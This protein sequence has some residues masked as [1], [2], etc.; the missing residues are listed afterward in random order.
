MKFYI[1]KYSS[2]NTAYDSLY[3]FIKRTEKWFNPPISSRK[4]LKDYVEKLVDE[5]VI[6]LAKDKSTDDIIGIA[7]YYCTPE[8]FI[9][10]RTSYLAALP[11]REGIGSNLLS[12]VI[13]DCKSKGMCWIESQTWESNEK[14][15]RL[16]QK[17]GYQI[18][19]YISNR[20]NNIRSVILRL[21]FKT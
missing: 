7:A 18:K 6:L 5:A 16:F 19:E 4:S 10:A 11:N 20:N 14:S 15:I 1:V 17:H 12:H 3:S 9:F 13:E 2:E 21:S 8:K